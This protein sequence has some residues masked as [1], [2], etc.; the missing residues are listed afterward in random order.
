MKAGNR[1]YRSPDDLPAAIPVFP[2]PAALLL[3]RSELPL[4][5][6]EP[7]Y[8]AMID[9]ALAGDRIVG[10]IQPD[11]GKGPGSLGP[12][13]CTVGC[14]GRITAF[15][16]TGDGRYMVTLTGIARFVVTEEL[17]TTTLFR[18]CRI[19][20]AVRRAMTATVRM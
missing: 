1:P 16:E 9:A 20:A 12:S 14:A 19:S 10:M 5:I 4:N 13:L 2:L 17:V 6:F 8:V 3:P 15:A 18:Q 11:E 7:R